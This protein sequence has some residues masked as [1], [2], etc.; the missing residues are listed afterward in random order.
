MTAV[1][2]PFAS[3]LQIINRASSTTLGEGL[4]SPSSTRSYCISDVSE[5]LVG[6]APSPGKPAM[7]SSQDYTPGLR[8]LSKHQSFNSPGGSILPPAP[9]AAPSSPKKGTVNRSISSLFKG[10][11]KTKASADGAGEGRSIPSTP[12]GAHGEGSGDMKRSN[13]LVNQALRDP[14]P[15]DKPSALHQSFSDSQPKTASSPQEK[16]LQKSNSTA[17]IE[18]EVQAAMRRATSIT[19]RQGAPSTLLAVCKDLPPKMSRPVWNL[20]D[21]AVVEKLYTGETQQHMW[22]ACMHPAAGANA[23]RALAGA[24]CIRLRAL[25]TS[26]AQPR[27]RLAPRSNHQAMH[28]TCTRLSAST[29]GRQCASNPTR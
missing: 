8:S 24:A 4:A 18:S 12:T 21:Y 19:G 1:A 9:G 27:S 29:L 3:S 20:R 11:F 2:N 23:A 6:S 26:Q 22:Y 10:L 16:P 7:S 17:L 15:K 28:P 25:H 14:A 13:S 5:G